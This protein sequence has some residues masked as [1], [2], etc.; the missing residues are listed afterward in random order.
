MRSAFI[1]K[2]LRSLASCQNA[3]LQA[4][5][6]SARRLALHISALVWH[7]DSKT[8]VYIAC[9]GPESVIEVAEA[10]A[11]LAR[12]SL[13]TQASV[14][15]LQRPSGFEGEV[16]C[17]LRIVEGRPPMLIAPLEHLLSNSKRRQWG[18]D[19]QGAGLLIEDASSVEAAACAAASFEWNLR[20]AHASAHALIVSDL[21]PLG[22]FLWRLISA[23]Q[24]KPQQSFSGGALIGFLDRCGMSAHRHSGLQ[25]ALAGLLPANLTARCDVCHIRKLMETLE[26]VFSTSIIDQH[27]T[28]S[29]G[30][31]MLRLG[32]DLDDQSVCLWCLSPAITFR[33]MATFTRSV[34]L[35][36]ASVVAPSYPLGEELQIPLQCRFEAPAFGRQRLPWL[37]VMHSAHTDASGLLGWMAVDR[38]CLA[39]LE[40]CRVVPESLMAV[41]PS[42]EILHTFQ[43]R[44]QATRMDK[45]LAVH[46]MLLPADSALTHH[47]QARG[48]LILATLHTASAI[49]ERMQM[50]ADEDGAGGELRC[51]IFCGVPERCAGNERVSA[52]A[53]FHQ[54]TP[55][56]SSAWL[57]A[58][59]EQTRNGLLSRHLDRPGSSVVLLEPFSASA[60]SVVPAMSAMASLSKACQALL[61]HFTNAA[62][63]A[64]ALGVF[65]RDQVA[66]VPDVDGQTTRLALIAQTS[67]SNSSSTPSPG[68]INAAKQP[69][70][71]AQPRVPGGVQ[72]GS[73]EFAALEP[74]SFGISLS[75]KEQVPNLQSS[76]LS[77]PSA[78]REA[79]SFFYDVRQTPRPE[80]SRR[81]SLSAL[82]QPQL[83]HP[84]PYTKACS[85]P[86]VGLS[87]HADDSTPISTLIG[88]LPPVQSSSNPR[89][90][91]AQN[92]RRRRRIQR[93]RNQAT[94]KHAL[95]LGGFN[96]PYKAPRRE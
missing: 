56:S 46:K 37:G 87:T 57:K 43:Q 50:L 86:H 82:A 68:I 64:S 69:A 55:Q 65:Y 49:Y 54:S 24:Q 62:S 90:T 33:N 12:T 9:G 23:I 4:E 53:H 85:E 41:F 60:G 7:R 34:I 66:D 75:S 84:L 91:L 45:T 39:L 63:V 6:T 52:R 32:G 61:A 96:Q 25:R 47:F 11:Q 3:S 18:L 30:S 26:L 58:Q 5:P 59:A 13:G 95:K 29:S 80:L 71:L 1:D 40:C 17:S 78:L 38:V 93:Q 8:P 44:L 36:S 79:Q 48:A 31:F 72:P 89:T 74:A 73:A 77:P 88:S 15:A 2:C 35:S 28:D 81:L 94:D 27:R 42:A 83:G 70:P 10:I 92:T 76:D 19:L 22:E 16:P 51:L 67:Q 20:A 14:S 21:A